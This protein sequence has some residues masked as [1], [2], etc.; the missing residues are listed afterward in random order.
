MIPLGF[1]Q[2]THSWPYY[3]KRLKCVLTDARQTEQD[4]NDDGT[5]SDRSDRN[6]L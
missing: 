5:S 2:E 1:L 6:I 3:H 4:I